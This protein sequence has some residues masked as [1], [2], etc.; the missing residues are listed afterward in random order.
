MVDGVFWELIGL[1]FA[2]ISIG[3]VI[4]IEMRKNRGVFE[5][6]SNLFRDSIQI[7]VDEKTAMLY[8]LCPIYSSV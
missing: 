1:T 5:R 6:L 8:G 2:I 3:V 4:V 7:T